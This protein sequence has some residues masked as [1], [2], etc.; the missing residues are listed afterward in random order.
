MTTKT[1]NY[2]MTVTI[3]FEL[4]DESN[5]VTL[6][7]ISTL[8]HDVAPALEEVLMDVLNDE[9]ALTGAVDN[10]KGIE[11]TVSTPVTR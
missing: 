1:T 9:I 8:M 2:E 11:V 4:D 5:A 7:D 6:H 10:I 3:T